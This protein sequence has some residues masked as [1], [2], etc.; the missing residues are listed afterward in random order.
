MPEKSLNEISRAWRDQ[1]E[2]GVAAL[3]RNNLDYAI[4]IFTQVL[5]K[6]PAFYA[7]REALRATQYKKF[8][9]TTGFFKKMLGTASSSPM[10]AKGQLALRTAPL[11]ALHIAEQILNGDPNNLSAHRMLVD[12]A[13]AAELPK[14]ALLSMEIIFKQAPDRPT[15]VK[16]A[17]VL[18]LN[19]LTQRA[20]NIYDE[21]LKGNPNDA[22]VAQ[23]AKNLAAH[24]TL[25]EGGYEAIADGQGSY[26]DILKDKTQAVSL[27]QESRLVKADEV[28]DRLIQEQEARLAQEPN[29]LKVMR[30]IG[31]LYTQ[32]KDFDRALSYFQRITESEGGGDASL[33]RLITDTITRKYDHALGQL[34]PQS[35]DYATET[36]RVR[37]EKQEYLLADAKRRADRYPNDLQIRFELGQQYFEAGKISEAIQEFQRA[38]SNPHKR[39]QA[40]SYLGQCFSKRG[41]NDLAARTLQNAIKEK[42]VFDDEKKDLIYALGSAYERMNK[43]EEAVEQ[44]KLIYETDIGYR[45]VAAKVDAYYASKGA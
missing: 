23:A 21:L 3:Q 8:G 37:K 25:G 12:A 42:L 5:Q 35:A 1:Y 45:D 39:I 16:L 14:T 17:E 18:V 29:N 33:E 11:D 27:E 9:S 36:A 43:P 4:T 6:E 7:C 20:A 19:G 26:R 2:K 38:Q 13:L 41:M 28:S 31:E 15:A 24:R 10:L 22:A 34:D 30:T 40:M 32:K 44:F